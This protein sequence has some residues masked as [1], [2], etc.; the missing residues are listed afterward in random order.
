MVF[1]NERKFEDDLCGADI[2]QMAK[3]K[4]EMAGA[5]QK[6]KDMPYLMESEY[7]GK[8]VRLFKG[9]DNRACAVKKTACGQPEQTEGCQGVYQREDRYHA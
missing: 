5:S 1:Y 8:R 6:N 3:Y 2:H 9:I 4:P 7:A